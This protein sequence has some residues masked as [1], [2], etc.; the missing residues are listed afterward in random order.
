MS[1]IPCGRS[2]DSFIPC[3]LLHQSTRIARLAHPVNR[4]IQRAG[5]RSR[6]TGRYDLSQPWGAY[7]SHQPGVAVQ[8]EINFGHGGSYSNVPG[9]PVQHEVPIAQAIHPNRMLQARAHTPG[10]YGQVDLASG[11][12]SFTHARHSSIVAS[13]VGLQASQCHTQVD[14]ADKDGCTHYPGQGP[15]PKEVAAFCTHNAWILDR[16]AHASAGRSR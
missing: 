11:R 5:L 3:T 12:R 1:E 13:W 7:Y 9:N 10:I 2:S 15:A 4:R 16:N 14:I 6:A 8:R